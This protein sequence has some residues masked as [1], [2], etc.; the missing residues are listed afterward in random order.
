V[1]SGVINCLLAHQT[2]DLSLG[3]SSLRVFPA[4]SGNAEVREYVVVIIEPTGNWRFTQV[5]RDTGSQD[6]GFELC[7]IR[8]TIINAQA[9]IL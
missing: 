2:A 8:K 3:V 7:L 4:P 5:V 9:V 6:W 1:A